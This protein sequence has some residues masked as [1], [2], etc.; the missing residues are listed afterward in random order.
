MTIDS[1]PRSYF[2]VESGVPRSGTISGS[3]RPPRALSQVW[4]GAKSGDM[5]DYFGWFI[6]TSSATPI[7]ISDG[8]SHFVVLC[9]GSC[10]WSYPTK[11]VL[12]IYL[13]SRWLTYRHLSFTALCY[14]ARIAFHIGLA[15][16]VRPYQSII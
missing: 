7:I 14:F 11:V 9:L 8:H 4:R 2:R 16:A 12:A 6:K 5:T 13:Y 1:A 10:R 15:C 3:Q